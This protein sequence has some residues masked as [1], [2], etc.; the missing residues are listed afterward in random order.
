MDSEQRI[1]ER[2]AA[3]NWPMAVVRGGAIRGPVS[4]A[5][6]AA[7]P[8]CRLELGLLLDALERG[9]ASDAERDERWGV[10][11]A[12]RAAIGQVDETLLGQERIEALAAAQD[13][14]AGRAAR[15][16]DRLDSI[17]SELRSISAALARR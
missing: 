11:D 15:V 14:V 9:A 5:R 1:L 4:W 10:E 16:E 17:L 6:E 12:Q 7:L 3:L 8:A 13:W 2:A